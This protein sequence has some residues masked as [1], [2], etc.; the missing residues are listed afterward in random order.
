[1]A[2]NKLAAPIGTWPPYR[3]GVTT[4]TNITTTGTGLTALTNVVK[5]G[6]SEFFMV[7]EKP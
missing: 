1:M 3:D 5:I 2:T 7:I 6:P 4:Y